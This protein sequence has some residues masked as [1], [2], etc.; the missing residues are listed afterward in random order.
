MG[1]TIVEKILAKNS[2][3]AEVKPGDIIEAK[4]D[5]VMLHDIGTPGIQRPLKE[6]GL[7]RIADNVECVIIP[8]HFV[9]APTVQ[10]AEN[11]KITR[12]FA[13]SMG[14]KNFYDI[15]RGGVCHQVM[16]EKGHVRPGQII[17]APDS[18]A[19]TYGSFGALG[20][21]FGVTDVAIALGTGRLWF[22]VPETAKIVLN[23][24][25][26]AG[27]SAKDVILHLLKTF[28]EARFIYKVIEL[29]GPVIE[30]MSMEGR[31]CIANLAYE[32]GVK[33]CIILPDKVTKDYLTER[34]DIAFEPVLPDPDAQYA[35][36]LE[37]DLSDLA[38][39]V[40]APHSPSNGKTAAEAAGTKIHQ[41]FL[42]SCTNGRIEDLRIAADIL[43]GQTVHPDVRLIVTPAS[44]AVYLQAVSEGI[45]EVLLKAGACITNPGCGVCLGGHLGVIA[46][47]EVCISTSNRNFRGR[48]GS[49]NGAIYLAS[50]ATVAA[51]AIKGE[52]TDPRSL[53]VKQA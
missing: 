10:A 25:L 5:A 24:R 30:N 12:N 45:V 42:G 13:V 40:A 19:T 48:M 22:M 17:A 6:L 44:Q 26:G 35:E 16:V 14:V 51:S 2:G 34:T 20:T 47:D 9:P 53:E 3:M 50:P 23:G 33:T 41:A 11:L 8:D 38:P 52:I 1:M 31:M 4:V 18:H 7:D 43:K 27:V 21:G 49:V 46:S 29:S 28:G 37:L 15:G 39:M 32:L 36:T